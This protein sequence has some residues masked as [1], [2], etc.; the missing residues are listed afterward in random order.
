MSTRNTSVEACIFNTGCR[1]VSTKESR[2]SRE[3]E[4]LSKIR[5]N[6][7]NKVVLNRRGK[8]TPLKKTDSHSA[9]STKQ[10]PLGYVTV[11]LKTLQQRGLLHNGN[12]THNVNRVNE[13]TRLVYG[14]PFQGGAQV[15]KEYEISQE[16]VVAAYAGYYRVGG[17]TLFLHSDGSICRIPQTGEATRCSCNAVHG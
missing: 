13:A 15:A 1:D 5:K 17:K 12:C 14:N 10:L 8:A 3:L 9:A 11:L 2:I 4:Q 6:N 7:P 16:T